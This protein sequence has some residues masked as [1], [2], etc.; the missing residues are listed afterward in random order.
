MDD[1]LAMSVLSSSCS[2]NLSLID[3]LVNNV[4]SI[5]ADISVILLWI[6]LLDS[7]TELI[8]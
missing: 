1:L 8:F 3:S 6:I 5:F 7:G 4:S 2:A